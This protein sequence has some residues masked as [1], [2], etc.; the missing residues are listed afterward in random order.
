[1]DGAQD[2]SVSLLFS[3]ST[4]Q[5]VAA[6]LTGFRQRKFVDD[7]GA[8]GKEVEDLRESAA[9]SEHEGEELARKLSAGGD[10]P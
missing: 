5:P 10:R 2:N 4:I 9:M 6:E 7:I 3:C 8:G 1:M